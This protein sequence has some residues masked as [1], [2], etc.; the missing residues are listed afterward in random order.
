MT[1]HGESKLPGRVLQHQEGEGQG[2][3][4]ALCTNQVFTGEV[5][6]EPILVSCFVLP[7]NWPKKKFCRTGNRSWVSTAHLSG[8]HSFLC[9][10][11]VGSIREP[12]H[13]EDVEDPWMDGLVGIQ[14]KLFP[15]CFCS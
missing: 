2:G 14:P 12:P 11:C 10:E 6:P 9:M 1:F 3:A 15:L 5:K 7:Q 4:A 8:T 13:V